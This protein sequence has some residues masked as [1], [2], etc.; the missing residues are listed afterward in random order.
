MIHVVTIKNQHYYGHQLDQMFR[1]RHEFYVEGHGWDA[2]DSQNGRE[3][4]QFDDETAV[5]LISLDRHGEVAAALRLHPTTGPNLTAHLHHYVE[6]EPPNSTEIWDMTRWIVAPAYRGAPVPGQL[7][8]GQEMGCGLMEFALKRGLS[9]FSMIAETSLIY[10]LDII[11]WR[12]HY[13]GPEIEYD[14]GKGTARALLLEAGP[15]ALMKVR[16]QLGVHEDVLFQIQP[17]EHALS[18]EDQESEEDKIAARMSRIGR[19]KSIRAVQK[20]TDRLADK[21]EDDPAAAIDAI[22]SYSNL[23]MTELDALADDQEELTNAESVGAQT[24]ADVLSH[25]AS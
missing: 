21:I 3:T 12:Y 9:H 17:M 10:K 14:N 4:D 25:K 8:P 19:L 13:I 2:M 6:G 5:Y 18:A 7:M 1:M 20:L 15:E 23:L 11:G 24:P 16:A 22:M